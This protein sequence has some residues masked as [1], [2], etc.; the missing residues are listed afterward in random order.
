MTHF[1]DITAEKC[2]MTFVRM[3]LKLEQLASGDLLEVRFA[4]AEPLK[5]LPRNA[6]DEGHDVLAITPDEGGAFRLLIRK[7][8]E[9]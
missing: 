4:G 9:K 8:K 3:K 7:H 1:L 5:N 2:P 6:S